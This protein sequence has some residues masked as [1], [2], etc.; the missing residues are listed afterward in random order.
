[1][2]LLDHFYWGQGKDGKAGVWPLSSWRSST[3]A[4]GSGPKEGG[5]IQGGA[6]MR[7]REKVVGQRW[8]HVALRLRALRGPNAC[9]VVPASRSQVSRAPRV[10]AVL[11]GA[12]E[13]RRR[14]AG[15]SE[16]DR[17]ALRGGVPVGRRPGLLCLL[18]TLH[19]PSKAGA[20]PQ[21][22]FRLPPR[23]HAPPGGAALPRPAGRQGG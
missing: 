8:R 16:G 19:L 12:R 7:D 1:M 9:W 5:R 17:G 10:A 11:P 22:P 14:R 18:W 6:W 23:P 3:P 15:D 13:G 2:A 4:V 20:D 21:D